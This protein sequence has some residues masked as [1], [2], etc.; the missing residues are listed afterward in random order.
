MTRRSMGRRSRE[1]SEQGNEYGNTVVLTVA[2]LSM[3]DAPAPSSRSDS[4]SLRFSTQWTSRSRR[5]GISTEL[6]NN[7]RTLACLETRRRALRGTTTCPS[8]SPA[9]IVS[10][11][12]KS[13]MS[14]VLRT[15]TQTRFSTSAATVPLKR[16]VPPRVSL[17]PPGVPLRALVVLCPQIM[18]QCQG[19]LEP[20]FHAV[21]PLLRKK[22][23]ASRRASRHDSATAACGHLPTST[24]SPC[25]RQ[26]NSSLGTRH[27]GLCLVFRKKPN[28]RRPHR[29]VHMQPTRSKNGECGRRVQCGRRAMAFQRRRW[30]GARGR[31]PVRRRS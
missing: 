7:C 13:G 4:T 24:D 16:L 25:H 11:V 20:I 21:H 2:V 29:T 30:R 3:L 14:A 31:A 22:H 27:S 10:A 6:G 18:L 17:I 5:S 23:Q 28:P 15:R 19:S 8:S 12:G 26:S 9:K 1:L